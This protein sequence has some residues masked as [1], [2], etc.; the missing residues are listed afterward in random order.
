MA[1]TTRCKLASVATAVLVA[2]AVIL[3][4][5]FTMDNGGSADSTQPWV[6]QDRLPETVVPSRYDIL[7]YPNLDAGTFTGELQ[8]PLCGHQEEPQPGRPAV[9]VGVMF[10]QVFTV[11]ELG[12]VS[13]MLMGCSVVW[14]CILHSNCIGG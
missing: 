10:P 9:V 11:I 2:I 1:Y 14:I 5:V 13:F 6:T 8:R 4:V 3:I 12:V 7:L